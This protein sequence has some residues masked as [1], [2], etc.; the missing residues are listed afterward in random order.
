VERARLEDLWS[1]FL[2]GGTLSPEEDGALADALFAD[3][4]LRAEILGDQRVDGVLRGL[5]RV[6]AEA[7]AFTEG[8]RVRL[9][10][11]RDATRFI[12]KIEQRLAASRPTHRYRARRGGGEG[13]ERWIAWALAAAAL[14]GIVLALAVSSG[15][16]PEGPR[17]AAREGRAPSGPTEPAPEPVPSPAP[18]APEHSPAAPEARPPGERRPEAP[19]ARNEAVPA[20]QPIDKPEPPKPDKPTPTRA[21]DEAGVVAVGTLERAQGQVVVA[22][23]LPGQAGQKIAAGDSVECGGRSGAVFRFADGSRLELGADTAVRRFAAASAFVAQGAVAAEVVRQ[24]PGA[25]VVLFTPH[26]EA[27]VLGTRFT[28]TVSARG[29]RLD[30]RE[31]RVR[32]TRLPDGASVDVPGGYYAVAAPGTELGLRSEHQVTVSFQDGVSPT[33]KYEG[34]RDTTISEVKGDQDRNQGAQATLW[35]DGSTRAAGEDRFI[36][37]RWDV[38]AIPPGSQVLSASLEFH[39][40]NHSAGRPF[41]ILEMKRD[42]VENQATWNVYASKRPWQLPGAQGAQDHGAAVGL[43]APGAVGPYVTILNAAGVTL[44]QSWVDVPGSNRGILVADTNNDD[45]IGWASREA[46]NPAARP[47]LTVVFVPRGARPK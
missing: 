10:S 5:S 29:T 3:P 21:T 9:K 8:V 6:G 27:R 42:W 47:K 44:V 22:R 7:E 38:S 12:R 26:A 39:V 14:F 32:L 16:A 41:E 36:L 25:A 23:K 45:A 43:A 19:P 15:R 24:A 18:K 40:S 46:P 28:L 35:V 20:A 1:R 11:E 34:T 37:L 13:F 17:S 33:P 4:R 30:V 31:G 2:S